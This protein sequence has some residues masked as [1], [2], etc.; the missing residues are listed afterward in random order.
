[1]GV[2]QCHHQIHLHRQFLDLFKLPLSTIATTVGCSHP[3]TLVLDLSSFLEVVP[4]SHVV[5]TSSHVLP[6]RHEFVPC[7]SHAMLLAIG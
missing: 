7:V 6:A 2:L 3:T 1:M 4:Q 5:S